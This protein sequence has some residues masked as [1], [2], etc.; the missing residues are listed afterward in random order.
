MNVA[1]RRVGMNVRTARLM[2]ET[3]IQEQ[4]KKR[5]AK[6]AWTELCLICMAWQGWDTRDPFLTSLQIYHHVA[7]S[8]AC[9][10]DVYPG[11]V[12]KIFFLQVVFL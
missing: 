5:L 9:A 11:N 7:I 10:E 2:Q 12:P 6:G 1:A 4:G 8:R 3:Y